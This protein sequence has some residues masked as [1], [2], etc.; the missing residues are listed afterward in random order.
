MEASWDVFLKDFD[1]SWEEDLLKKLGIFVLLM[2]YYDFMG[3][4]KFA[5]KSINKGVHPGKVCFID[6]VST[7]IDFGIQP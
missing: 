5:P 4:A 2:I 3:L 1:K 7:L 6:F